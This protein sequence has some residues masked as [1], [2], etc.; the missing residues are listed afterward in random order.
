MV[1]RDAIIGNVA[2][3]LLKSFGGIAGT[4][5]FQQNLAAIDQP[6]IIAGV[7]FQYF[8][9]ELSSFVDAIFQDQQLNVVFLDLDITRMLL[10]ESGV[11]GNRFIKVSDGEIEVAQHAISHGVVGKLVPGVLQKFLRLGSF[12]L[13]DVETS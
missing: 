12:A 5:L 3:R 13:N 9:V 1:V 7:S 2:D 11:L 10:E 8:V 6:L 4:A